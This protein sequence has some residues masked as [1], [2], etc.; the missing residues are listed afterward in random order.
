MAAVGGPHRG[1]LRCMARRMEPIVNGGPYPAP[2]KR[3]IAGAGMAGDQEHHPAARSDRSFQTAV[4]GCPRPVE[5]EAVEVEHQVGVDGARAKP[6]VP[7]GIER[8][9][10]PRVGA[11]TGRRRSAQRRPARLGRLRG[12]RLWRR[13]V[14]R[15][16]GKRADGRGDPRPE[17]LL[18]RAERAHA[19]QLPADRRLW[20]PAPAPGHWPPSHRRSAAPRR[21]LPR[22]CRPG[23]RP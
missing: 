20:G 11:G 10:G 17:R 3:R 15:F 1:D 23:W 8:R 13:L 21:R 6:P 4:D 22:R 2:L 12:G 14:Q 7:A 18:V 9:S 16:A 19:R 5:V